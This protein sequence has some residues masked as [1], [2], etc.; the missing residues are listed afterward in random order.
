MNGGSGV[1]IRHAD[2]QTTSLSLPV[3][4]LSTNLGNNSC[5]TS[6][7]DNTRVFEECGHPDRLAL[8]TPGARA[9]NQGSQGK[10][11]RPHSPLQSPSAVDPSPLWYSREWKGWLPCQERKLK[12]STPSFHHL[13]KI[14][15][16]LKSNARDL[17][18]Q[19]HGGYTETQPWLPEIVRQETSNYSV[20]SEDRTLLTPRPLV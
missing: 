6:P 15:T 3:G 9:C 19:K 18:R 11:T 1:Y 2:G 13:Q 7:E 5:I 14:R 8:S 17:F 16:I 20:S 4:Q 12:S 10:P